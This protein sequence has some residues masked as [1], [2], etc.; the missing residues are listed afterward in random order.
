MKV[1]PVSE[2]A[3]LTAESREPN[4]TSTQCTTEELP[5]YSEQRVSMLETISELESIIRKGDDQELPISAYPR[6]D[7]GHQS[8]TNDLIRHCQ[9]A[10]KLYFDAIKSGNIENVSAFLSSKLVTVE[11]TGEDGK[12][13]LLAAIDGDYPY[14][15]RY[16]LDIGADINAYGQTSTHVSWP[17]R[18]GKKNEEHIFR[19]PLQ[20]AAST[21]NL[22]IVKLLMER[23][24]NDALVA[25]DGQL[26]LRLA[27]TNGHR[28]IVD[29]LPSRRGGGYK[30]WKAKHRTAMR[31]CE[32]A[33]HGIYLCGRFFVWEIPKFFLWSIPKHC[34]VR[35]AVA[36]VKWVHKHRAEIPKLL[37]DAAKSVARGLK[38]VPARAWASLKRLPGHIWRC[39][40]E[41]SKFL[42]R[43]IKRIPS[44]VK[45]AL[46]WL[47]GGIKRIGGAIGYALNR[48]FS[49][50]H[51]VC[52]AVASFFKQITL[53]DVV[54]AF[55]QCFGAIF[56][57][58][59]KKI[60][61]WM[62]KFGDV[63]LKVLRAIFGCTG[64][65]IWILIT[66]LIEAVI[67][68]PKKLWVILV[69]CGASVSSGGKEV[70]VWIDPK[71]A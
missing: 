57:D 55:K 71:R 61:E 59:P 27:A 50:I 44:G 12:T 40:K 1:G 63:S 58:A 13:P 19:T 15:I 48:F 20:H 3:A 9:S 45:I 53:Q 60:W 38:K 2:G 16:L 67:Y 68:V 21:G 24:A 54:N 11:T 18:A 65:C 39:V 42:W 4:P 36:W 52:A 8:D 31:R 64:E 26:A 47:W 49:F 66:A 25:P 41:L 29:Y 5:L 28:E 6:L 35:P 37:G 17:M 23:G 34:V 30:R 14:M 33:V 10:I 69:A 32:R 7:Y 43:S 46:I 51:T 62:Q 56:I 22:A 70:L